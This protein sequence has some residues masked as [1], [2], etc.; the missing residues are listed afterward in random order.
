MARLLLINPP[1][2]PGHTNER[3]QSGGIGVSRKL[4]PREFWQPGLPP[5][6][7]LNLAATA[8]A[9]GLQVQLIDLL[10]EE[11][12]GEQALDFIERRVGPLHKDDLVGVRL[13][14]PSLPLDLA[15]ANATK[16]RFPRA[17][18]FGFG[19]VIMSTYRHWI[20]ACHLD[21]LVYGE[22]EAVMPGV[23]A[24]SNWHDAEGIIDVA[25]YMPDG[26]DPFDPTTAIDYLKW[27]RTKELAGIER[28]AWHLVEMHRYAVSGKA[29]DVGGIVQASRGCPI[30]CN[31]CAYT[32]LEGGP[33]RISQGTRVVDEIAY[34]QETYG[35]AHFRFRD[36]N[37][38]YDRKLLKSIL[39]E[40]K[41]RGIRIEA[42]AELS[43]EMLDRATL[44]NMYDA[45]IRTILT[46]IETDDPE[47]MQSVGQNIK[48]NPLIKQK[49]GWC[50]EIG[51]KVYTFFLIGMP[52]ESWAS[53]KRTIAFGKQLGTES[54]LTLLSP[55]PGTGIY[56]RTIKE[57]LLPK[58]M[59]YEKF[60][61]Y[62]ATARTYHLNLTELERARLWARLELILPYRM[63]EAR[64]RGVGAV[65]STAVRHTPHYAIRQALRSYVWW[66][67]SIL[68]ALKGERSTS[69]A[70]QVSG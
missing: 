33:L 70:A 28:P 59:V 5:L 38:S 41:D 58:E 13:S 1:A 55:F 53:I 9:L 10:I 40:L 34:L 49:L 37:F 7:M 60:N 50:E 22:P 26:K 52:E 39:A 29:S 14:I 2:Q 18:I 19:G 24:T 69:V 16:G 8:E 46:G 68:P 27:V 66:R 21:F 67:A 54:T 31:M 47:C 42:T 25:N 36:A 62:T 57:G 63:K 6:D 61:S 23:L 51:I 20:D 43:L 15:F 48:V 64:K 45:G 17:R 32:M 35:I 11:L 65:V 3:D 56:W 12:A 44:Q 30:G 4:K